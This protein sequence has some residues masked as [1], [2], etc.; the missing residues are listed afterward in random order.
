MRRLR[1]TDKSGAGETSA[2]LMEEQGTKAVGGRSMRKITAAVSAVSLPPCIGVKK[3][4]LPS[5][6][7]SS[8]PPTSLGPG[9][10]FPAG[11]TVCR[12]GNGYS[13]TWR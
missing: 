5:V 3:L 9:K 6:H 10:D 13:F 8:L 2:V 12:V 7:L 11:G 1:T 4:P